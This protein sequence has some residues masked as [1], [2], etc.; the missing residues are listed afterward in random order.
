MSPQ[1]ATNAKERQSYERA[2]H[3]LK[4]NIPEKRLDIHLSYESFRALEVQAQ[5]LYGNAK[6]MTMIN[7][8]VLVFALTARRYACAC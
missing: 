7:A 1:T 8:P 5:A 3:F 2:L 6:Y 4:A